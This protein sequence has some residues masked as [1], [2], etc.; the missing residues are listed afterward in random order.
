MAIGV[1]A[2]G[3][4]ITN[5]GVELAAVTTGSTEGVLTSFAVEFAR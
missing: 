4:L 5:P 3:S 1:L 2:Y